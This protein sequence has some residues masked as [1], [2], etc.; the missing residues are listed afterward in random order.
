MTWLR[1]STWSDAYANWLF[2]FFLTFPLSH[3][4]LTSVLSPSLYS[5]FYLFLFLYNSVLLFS[6]DDSF[7]FPCL[8]LFLSSP[9]DLKFSQCLMFKYLLLFHTFYQCC[10]GY[11]NSRRLPYGINLYSAITYS[12]RIRSLSITT[13]SNF[14]PPFFTRL[15]PDILGFTNS[16]RLFSEWAPWWLSS[17]LSSSFSVLLSLTPTPGGVAGGDM[18]GSVSLYDMVT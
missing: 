17:S 9:Q 2:Y 10:R 15:A 14:S 16:L 18:D 13:F 5:S 8:S 7:Y 4:F 11:I 12:A 6:C 3:L 1:K